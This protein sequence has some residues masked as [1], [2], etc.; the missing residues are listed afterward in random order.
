[1][2]GI[3]TQ[4]LQASSTLMI[5]YLEIGRTGTLFTTL[6]YVKDKFKTYS[7]CDTNDQITK[8]IILFKATQ[9]ILLNMKLGSMK[10]LNGFKQCKQGIG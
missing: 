9:T 1:M 8:G 7:N 4:F 3:Y 2:Y 6:S 5:I 10:V